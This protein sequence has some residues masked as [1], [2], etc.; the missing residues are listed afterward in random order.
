MGKTK[1]ALTVDK[2]SFNIKGAAAKPVGT[3]RTAGNK[4][5]L[6]L[7]VP[8]FE[9]VK[10]LE[11]MAI[12]SA[13]SAS[14]KR[15]VVGAAMIVPTKILPIVNVT[16]VPVNGATIPANVQADLQKI[17]GG[18]GVTI[19]VAIAPNYTSTITTLE[20]GTSGF[21]ANYTAEQKT[22][23]NNYTALKPAEA[24]QYYVFLMNNITPSRPIRGFMPLHRQTGFVFPNQIAASDP[25]EVNKGSV[26]NTIAHEIGHGIFELEHPWEDYSYAKGSQ[27]TNWLMDTEGGIK[28]P[29]MHWQKISHPKF[30]LYVFQK[31]NAGELINKIWFTPD[32]KA[33]TKV[34]ADYTCS[35]AGILVPL[36]TVPGISFNGKCYTATFNAK[37]EFIGYKNGQGSPLDIEYKSLSNKDEIYLYEINKLSTCGPDKTYRADYDYAI[38]NKTAITYSITN[39][40][41]TF[42]KNFECPKAIAKDGDFAS[43]FFDIQNIDFPPQAKINNLKGLDSDIC[44]KAI[45]DAGQKVKALAAKN[46]TAYNYS[47]EM[48]NDK[49]GNIYVDKDF[50]M[51]LNEVLYKL[52]HKL[53]YLSEFTK[54][55]IPIYVIFQNINFGINGNWNEY[56]KAVYKEAGL[57]NAILITVPNVNA[58]AAATN[59]LY[60][61]EVSHNMPGL[62]A[63][64]LGIATGKITKIKSTRYGMI[65]GTQGTPYQKITS[66]STID[67]INQVYTQTYKP[68]II[69]Y[70]KRS[71]EGT[72]AKIAKISDRNIPGNNF[73]KTILLFR[74]KYYDKIEKLQKPKA[75]DL[76]TDSPTSSNVLTLLNNNYESDL[77][78][79][80]LERATIIEEANARIN[81]KDDWISVENS[82]QFKE[83]YLDNKTADEYIVGYAFK[84][85][86]DNWISDL[87]VAF[88][89]LNEKPTIYKFENTYNKDKLS[90]IDP[91]VYGVIDGASLAAGFLTADAIPESF[92]LAYA[93]WRKDGMNVALYASCIVMPIISGGELRLAQA[94]IAKVGRNA[95]TF[96]K[97]FIHTLSTDG[98]LV[99][100][101]NSYV[102]GRFLEFFKLSDNATISDAE[103][104]TL[105]KAF[106]E[107]KVSN[108]KIKEILGE[109]DEVKR[110]SLLKGVNG[111]GSLANNLTGVLKTSY[112][113]LIT[114]GLNAVEEG[115]VIK[116]FNSKKALVAE[117][118]NNRLVFKYE[119]WGRDIITNSEKTTTCIAKFDDLLD[120]PGSK[121]IKN[122]LPEGSFGRGAENK[123][124]I[125]ILDV[126]DATY[127]KLSD[128][129][130]N[131]LKKTGNNTPTK[132]QIETEANEIFW[133]RYNLP[134]LEQAFAR[135]DDIRLLSE[136]STLFTSTGFYQ[137]EIEVIKQ[138]WTKADGTFVQPLKTKYN[139]K[140]NDLTKTYEKIK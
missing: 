130:V 61:D 107:G 136:P 55:A 113:K 120:A 23:I 112:N 96:Y 9:T 19:T 134:F 86:F 91:I 108:A 10:E 33:F 5:T 126:D 68:Y 97:G 60:K 15:T 122:D 45:A 129:A 34:G 13:A 117:I 133:N 44:K 39:D 131:N 8:V 95:K 37:N 114:A 125:N 72:I 56:T 71:V 121:W 110:V 123:G 138:G 41:I 118:S 139:Y 99:L 53:V 103:I 98:K 63:E 124:G 47:L 73:V 132:N 4:I 70:G 89:G 87:K 76:L 29:Y 51:N 77:L 140:F 119:G 1:P 137:R 100:S 18:I 43:N 88:G 79:Y 75:F 67:F 128:E 54:K 127:L 85:G 58:T 115:N 62:Y 82:I 26:T 30:G 57:R 69:Y 92:G 101:K 135:G 81:N 105:K 3:P 106:K 38:A 111:V 2:I 74:N 35:T 52:D 25:K 14:D 48:T 93:V 104:I 65:D 27:L 116:L 31:D 40:K 21:M 36:G 80:E 84:D 46:N 28:L 94:S 102:K 16:L 32:W 78:N 12:V 20:C 83:K 90:T 42:Y 59:G 50:P 6:T 64:G 11:L 66:E 24:N 49:M 17:Y 22:F 109:V 7:E